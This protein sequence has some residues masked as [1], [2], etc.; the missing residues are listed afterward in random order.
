MGFA[1]GRVMFIIIDVQAV[2]AQEE[3]GGRVTR[4]RKRV[5][6]RENRRGK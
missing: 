4:R 1:N 2:L 6:R 3:G 5:T